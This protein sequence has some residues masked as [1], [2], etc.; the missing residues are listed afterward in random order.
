MDTL[1][2]ELNKEISK[3][4]DV[5]IIRLVNKQLCLANMDRFCNHIIEKL[6]YKDIDYLYDHYKHPFV[7]NHYNFNTYYIKYNYH[8][9]VYQYNTDF[10]PN[11]RK[12]NKIY[13]SGEKVQIIGKYKLDLLSYDYLMTV[14]GCDKQSRINKLRDIL[15]KQYQLTK[16]WDKKYDRMIYDYLWFMTNA[17]VMKLLDYT[18]DYTYDYDP[19]I[20]KEI[21]TEIDLFYGLISDYLNSLNK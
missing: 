12:Y 10:L 8:H 21:K 5:N 17:I 6:N 20:I 16:T 2:F 1:P 4:I 9:V 18:Y 13:R 11:Q 14:K 15:N 3:N 19:R 7:I